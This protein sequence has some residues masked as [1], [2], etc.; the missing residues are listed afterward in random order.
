MR[1]KVST[2]LTKRIWKSK[3]MNAGDDAKKSDYCKSKHITDKLNH[4]Y[5]KYQQKAKALNNTRPYYQF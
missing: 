5:R 2:L 3:S 4:R 1:L